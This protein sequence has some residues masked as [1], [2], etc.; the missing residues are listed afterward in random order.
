MNGASQTLMVNEETQSQGNC[1]WFDVHLICLATILE[2]KEQL[3]VLTV[4]VLQIRAML[5]QLIHTQSLSAD[6]RERVTDVSLPLPIAS[7]EDWTRTE[8]MLGA[9]DGAKQLVSVFILR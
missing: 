1:L 9:D 3:A 8:T 7:L 5:E 6:Q 2:L 4:N